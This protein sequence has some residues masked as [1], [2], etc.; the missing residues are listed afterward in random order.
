MS[1]WLLGLWFCGLGIR[2]TFASAALWAALASS[3]VQ[4]CILPPGAMQEYVRWLICLQLA[5]AGLGLRSLVVMAGKA[6][7]LVV[8]ACRPC[9]VRR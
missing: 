4:P 9:S 5:Q 8:D 1:D 6:V 7:G 3:S 2:G